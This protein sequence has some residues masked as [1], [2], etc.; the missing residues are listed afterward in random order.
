MATTNFY[1]TRRQAL[2]H[3]K[4]YEVVVKT[5]VEDVDGQRTYGYT[6]VLDSRPGT[7]PRAR[8]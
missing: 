4:S 3:R 5:F 6:R 1:L 8:A 7:R 2:S